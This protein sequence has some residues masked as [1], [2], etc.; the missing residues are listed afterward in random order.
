MKKYIKLVVFI[1]SL[2]VVF[3][4]YKVFQKQ[5][6]KIYYIPLGDSIAEGM[7]SDGN[8]T[9]SYT[10]YIRDYYE[11]YDN[12]K[13]Y[14][15]KFTKSGY[16]INDVKND[17]E[18]NKTVDNIHLKEA[19]RESDLVTVSIGINN[20]LN[21]IKGI[22][23]CNIVGEIK[24]L[25]IVTDKILLEEKELIELIKKYAKG[26][27]ILVG[28]YNPC[29]NL[30]NSKEKIEEIIKY[31]NS[32]LEDLSNDENIEYIDIYS[33]FENNK[34]IL[35]NSNNIHPNTKGYRLIASE[36]I[37]RLL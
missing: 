25:K 24:D 22:K 9:N 26:K 2:F 29:P 36:I 13:F 27:I 21:N 33:L 6:E 1:I 3:M 17:I 11:T 5:Q 20:L 4:T 31:F 14:T 23:S 15:K 12:L 10:D 30:E 8:I 32:G 34:D 37:K 35:P 19:L 18:L 28:Y 7:D 16:K